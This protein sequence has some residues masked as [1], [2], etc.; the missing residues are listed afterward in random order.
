MPAQATVAL[1][2]AKRLEPEKAS[3]REAL[4]IAYFRLA[5]LG[6]GRGRVPR[7]ARALA[8]RRLRALRARP[9]A[10]EAGPRGRGERPLQARAARWARQRAATRR[11]SASSTSAACARSSSASA[12]RA[13]RRRPGAAR[14]GPAS[15]SCSAS[16]T[17]TTRPRAERLAGKVARL[18]IFEGDDGKF[19]RSL[20]DT[21]GAAL[22]VSQF[23]LIADTRE[24]NRP[25]F[26]DAARP[27]HAEPLYERFCEA[28]RDARRPGRDRRLR[29]ADGRSSSSTTA[30]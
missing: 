10:R 17:A 28:L 30:R 23:T 27:E 3:I 25:S 21:G 24:G 20:L 7:R 5:P 22:V 19:D 16:P 11:A 18:R 26:S 14:S 12:A 9:R 1:E 8:D 6:G 15:A 29:R 2:K 13:P 4:G